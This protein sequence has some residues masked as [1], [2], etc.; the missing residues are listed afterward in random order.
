[1]LGESERWQFLRTGRRPCSRCSE[2]RDT[3]PVAAGGHTLSH[4]PNPRHEALV[5][6]RRRQA[7]RGDASVPQAVPAGWYTSNL[8][9]SCGFR[10]SRYW[11][12][13]NT[14]S[15]SG[16]RGCST[17]APRATG[18]G[19]PPRLQ[20]FGVKAHVAAEA[21]MGDTV[22][23]S[24]GQHPRGRHAEQLRS[25]LGVE[26]GGRHY[27]APCAATRH[28]C[29][30]TSRLGLCGGVTLTERHESFDGRAC[31]YSP[32]Q[33]GRRRRGVEARRGAAI[34]RA[35]VRIATVGAR[36]SGAPN[37][38]TLNRPASDRPTH[39]THVPGTY[40]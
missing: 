13:A 15:L 17:S 11:V 30:E 28:R 6:Q 1:V 38:S 36:R 23:T 27:I 35:C 33:A 14:G 18:T 3:A 37:L 39:R 26:Q 29:P 40:R 16:L 5:G 9:C 12:R 10:P 19:T 2:R 34:A 7:L 22:G 31:P 24:L 4:R 8:A 25:V 20:L 32:V 21:N